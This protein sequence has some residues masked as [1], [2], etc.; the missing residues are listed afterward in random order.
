MRHWGIHYF[1]H[2]RE[3]PWS[4]RIYCSSDPEKLGS[5]SLSGQGTQ[6]LFS[7]SLRCLLIARKLMIQYG[8]LRLVTLSPSP[9]PLASRAPPVPT[10]KSQKNIRETVSSLPL[11]SQTSHPEILFTS[12]TLNGWSLRNVSSFPVSPIQEGTLAA[13]R[14]ECERQTAIPSTAAF[15][16]GPRSQ[17]PA[18]D[19][20]SL[21]PSYLL[22]KPPKCKNPVNRAVILKTLR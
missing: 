10:E 5:G 11:R 14:N 6:N 13:G 15:P 3:K 7:T 18:T 21:T 12:S 17:A 20:S 22:W 9:H 16:V 1:W 4:S 19:L 8:M 2:N